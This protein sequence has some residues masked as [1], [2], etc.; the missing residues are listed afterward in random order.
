MLHCLG[1]VSVLLPL[2]E[3]RSCGGNGGLSSA[4]VLR[5][6]AAMLAGCPTNQQAMQQIG[7]A[8][9]RP[10]RLLCLPIRKCRGAAGWV[11]RARPYP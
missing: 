11:C 4:G 6:L 2:L 10:T 8:A 5:L 7:G 1:G 3:E 9:A